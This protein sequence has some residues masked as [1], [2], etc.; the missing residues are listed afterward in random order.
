[1]KGSDTRERILEVAARLFREQ[2]FDGT[3]V[4]A[5][6]QDA[7]VNSGSLYHFFPGKEALLTGVLDQYV[8]QLYPEILQ[9]I[10]ENIAD[11]VERVFALLSH[12]RLG[13]LVSDC[14]RGCPVGDLALEMGDRIPH[15]RMVIS[16]YFDEWTAAVHRWLRDAADGLPAGLDR[17]ALSRLVLATMEGAVMQAR[18]ARDLGPFDACV[19]QLRRHFDLLQESSSAHVPAV[20]GVAAVSDGTRDRPVEIPATDEPLEPGAEGAEEAPEKLEWRAW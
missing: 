2:S 14:T 15:V 6:L 8:H 5:I 9:P 16:E 4:S 10:E 19:A 3:P 13:L 12:Y 1:M 7:D 20:A 17:P 18:A 11:P